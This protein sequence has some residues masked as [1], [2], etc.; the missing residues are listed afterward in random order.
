MVI[1]WNIIIIYLIGY[2]YGNV[3]LMVIIMEYFGI[4]YY[5]DIFDYNRNLLYGLIDG[6]LNGLF[7]C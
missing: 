2:G 4:D 5:C 6:L 7:K 3:I 1:E